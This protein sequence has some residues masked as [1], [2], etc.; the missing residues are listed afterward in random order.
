MFPLPF[1]NSFMSVLS[2]KLLCLSP[3][4]RWHLT[5]KVS[6]VRMDHP[7]GCTWSSVFI[8]ICT[9]YL[10]LCV[11]N[12]SVSGLVIENVRW[13]K[14][15]TVDRS[16]MVTTTNQFHHGSVGY[17]CFSLWVRCCK[18]HSRTDL[19]K[20]KWTFGEGDGTPLQY[21]CLENCMDGGAW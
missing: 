8:I 6:S 14:I 13:I 17:S 15:V 10:R 20:C 1:I 11:F 2:S 12:T 4:F 7:W 9:V 19:W 3:H 18:H 16:V 5:R 21:S